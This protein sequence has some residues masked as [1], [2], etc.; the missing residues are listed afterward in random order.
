MERVRFAVYDP[1]ERGLPFVAARVDQSG[2]T[3]VMTAKTR[4]EAEE[5]A[6]S[7]ARDLNDIYW[8]PE[9]VREFREKCGKA[10]A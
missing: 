6:L 5:A 4:R 2:N 10:N 9:A 7:M 8:F 3:R 1:P